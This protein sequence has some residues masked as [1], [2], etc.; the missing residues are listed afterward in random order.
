VHIIDLVQA[1]TGDAVAAV[2]LDGEVVVWQARSGQLIAHLATTV[3]SD[4]NRLAIVDAGAGLCVIAGSW[5]RR[6]VA[7]YDLTGAQLWVRSRLRPVA[8]VAPA[9][10]GSAIAVAFDRGPIQ[11]LDS[12]TGGQIWSVRGGRAYW[13]SPEV[14]VCAVEMASSVAI[15]ETTT[16]EQRWV[17]PVTGFAVLA[18]CFSRD[19]V[20]ISDTVTFDEPGRATVSCFTL[21]GT[22]EWQYQSGPEANVPWLGWDAETDQWL[23]VEHDVNKRHP[24]MLLRWKR[25]GEIVRRD[26]IRS[27]SPFVFAGQGKFLVSSDGRVRDTRTTDEVHRLR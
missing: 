16:W 2:G 9:R 18:A 26:A 24:P 11:I 4:T 3:E 27:S 14:A 5:E 13:Q 20:L 22:S 19:A 10:D 15:I 17:A 12:R 7:A 6:E 8:R 21:S 1:L 23:G 25:D